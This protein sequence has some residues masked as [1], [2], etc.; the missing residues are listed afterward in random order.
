M[1]IYCQKNTPKSFARTVSN[2]FVFYYDACFYARAAN[3]MK[4]IWV[5]FHLVVA[6]LFQEFF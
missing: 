4:L 1:S 6:R 5:T 3:K 2:L